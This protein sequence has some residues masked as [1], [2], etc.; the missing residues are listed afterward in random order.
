MLVLA[1]APSGSAH[2]APVV[3]FATGRARGSKAANDCE[4]VDKSSGRASGLW[5]A[6]A[7]NPAAMRLD[8]PL[9]RTHARRLHAIRLRGQSHPLPPG[10]TPTRQTTPQRPRQASLSSRPF[11]SFRSCGIV[12][13][14]TATPTPRA[15]PSF[16]ADHATTERA[17]LT[18]T[19]CKSYSFDICAR[20]WRK[21]EINESGVRKGLRFGVIVCTIVRATNPPVDK[22]HSFNSLCFSEKLS[23]ELNSRDGS[24][25][26]PSVAFSDNCSALA[27]QS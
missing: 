3:D 7:D 27:V 14:P 24:V 8:D 1:Y 26:R 22:M 25:S 11:A 18:V 12:A 6:I 17:Y 9:A 15:P 16:H 23:Q 2:N 5:Y 13:T 19:P 4:G 10:R 20:C 21:L